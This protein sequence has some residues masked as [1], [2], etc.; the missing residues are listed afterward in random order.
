MASQFK[1]GAA[2]A[3]CALSL[4][5]TSALAADP[6]F[7][8]SNAPSSIIDTTP[9]DDGTTNAVTVGLTGGSGVTATFTDPNNSGNF[10][11]SQYEAGFFTAWNQPIVLSETGSSGDTLDVSFSQAINAIQFNFSLGNLKAGDYLNVALYNGSTLVETVNDATTTVYSGT[12]Q[13]STGIFDYNGAA[14]TNLV[15][16]GSV[17]PTT[18]DA[19]ASINLAPVSVPVPEPATWALMG[20]GLSAVT[21]LARRRT[22]AV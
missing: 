8:F 20:V 14:I 7:N 1:L 19:L 9:I 4:G 15:I 10:Y 3:A 22:R 2:V 16:T 12:N 21:R 6:T 18:G 17:S 5:T 11:F 13:F